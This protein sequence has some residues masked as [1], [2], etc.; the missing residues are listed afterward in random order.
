MEKRAILERINGIGG[1]CGGSRRG[2]SIVSWEVDI[3]KRSSNAMG[4]KVIRR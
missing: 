2:S 4:M 3:L 1:S